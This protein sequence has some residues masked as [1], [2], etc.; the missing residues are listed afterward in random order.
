MDNKGYGNVMLTLCL[1]LV[2]VFLLHPSFCL[3]HFHLRAFPKST[4]TFRFRIAPDRV[5]FFDH[6]MVEVQSIL[7]AGESVGL[8]GNVSSI[9]ASGV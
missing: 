4:S 2:R 6:P 1:L 9:C 3:L 5:F 7:M 8:D